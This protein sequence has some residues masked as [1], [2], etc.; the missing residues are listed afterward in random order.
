MESNERG[1]PNF[2]TKGPAYPVSVYR[3]VLDATGSLAA[4]TGS[5]FATVDLSGATALYLSRIGTYA[6]GSF[7]IQL[8]DEG[9]EFAVI[10]GFSLRSSGFRRVKVRNAS[11]A[12][13]L[14]ALVTSGDPNFQVTTG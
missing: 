10:A 4:G 8:G 6:T 11:G 2:R 7:F 12:Q 3:M 9:P 1:V 14:V 5:E 13:V